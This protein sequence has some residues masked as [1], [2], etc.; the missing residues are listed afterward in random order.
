M[1]MRVLIKLLV[2]G[3]AA[4]FVGLPGG[5][6]AKQRPAHSL[7]EIFPQRLIDRIEQTKVVSVGL[8]CD[9]PECKCEDNRYCA[10]VSPH[11]IQ[12]VTDEIDESQVSELKSVLTDPNSYMVFEPRDMKMCGAADYLIAFL[13]FSGKERTGILY[14][15]LVV[16]LVSPQCNVAT[17]R[18]VGTEIYVNIDYSTARFLEIM[19]ALYPDDEDTA[20]YYKHYRRVSRVPTD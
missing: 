17:I 2:F 16:V 10:Y 1:R 11:K 20:R 8:I 3:V 7:H 18:C 5:A 6:L 9:S 4:L 15:D 19:F 14:D 13:L 12:E